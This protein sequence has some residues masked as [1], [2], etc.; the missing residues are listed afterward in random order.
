VSR[1]EL[2]PLSVPLW[3]VVNG[4]TEVW[5]GDDRKEAVRQARLWARSHPLDHIGLERRQWREVYLVETP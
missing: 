2:G 5:S 3:V 1:I 4:A